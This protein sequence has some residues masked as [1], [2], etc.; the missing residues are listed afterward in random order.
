MD[1]VGQPKGGGISQG[2]VDATNSQKK[3]ILD[4]GRS[5]KNAENQIWEFFCGPKKSSWPPPALVSTPAPPSKA[6]SDTVVRTQRGLLKVGNQ[7]DPPWSYRNPETPLVV[8]GG[9]DPPLINKWHQ[10]ATI[11]WLYFWHTKCQKKNAMNKQ[12]LD[13]CILEVQ[14]NPK[15]NTPIFGTADPKILAQPEFN[16]SREYR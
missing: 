10:M 6:H 8:V 9:V 16:L 5:Q 13:W 7:L 12:K 11:E 4:D 3:G 1:L 15:K 14:K 2:I